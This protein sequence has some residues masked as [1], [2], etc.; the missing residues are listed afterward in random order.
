LP[1]EEDM[2]RVHWLNF[3]SHVEHYLL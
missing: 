2:T 1:R 3:V